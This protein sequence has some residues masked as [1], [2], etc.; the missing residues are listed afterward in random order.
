MAFHSPT[1]I[2]LHLLI[3]LYPS[4]SKVKAYTICGIK[5]FYTLKGFLC[6]LYCTFLC[7]QLVIITLSKTSLKFV[8]LF[9]YFFFG[10]HKKLISF[11][12][13][14]KCTFLHVQV[15]SFAR[16]SSK[17]STNQECIIIIHPWTNQAG[18]VDNGPNQNEN[19]F[20]KILII[21]NVLILGRT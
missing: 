11:W 9:L 4:C 7:R 20:L 2:V 12:I 10:K 19:A 1:E 15:V 14:T 5:M 21:F 16:F 13:L 17:L 8:L 6:C 18:W 3:R